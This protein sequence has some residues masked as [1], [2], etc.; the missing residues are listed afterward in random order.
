MG[1][2]MRTSFMWRMEVLCRVTKRDSLF[3]G[4]G[5]VLHSRLEGLA[6]LVRVFLSPEVRCRDV[7][8]S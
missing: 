3:A 4:K 2:K 5:R 1:L 7:R 6:E 8:I